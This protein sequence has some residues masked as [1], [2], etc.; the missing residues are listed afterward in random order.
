MKVMKQ[1][2][3]N[4]RSEYESNGINIRFKQVGVGVMDFLKDLNGMTDSLRV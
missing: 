4:G 2:L 1:Q 3:I